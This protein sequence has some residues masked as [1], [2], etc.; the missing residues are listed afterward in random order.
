[1]SQLQVIHFSQTDL[2]QTI[3]F[4]TVFVYSPSNVKV[5]F[6]KINLSITTASISKSVLFNPV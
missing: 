2:I 5:L 3:Q 1:M 4:S 6:Q